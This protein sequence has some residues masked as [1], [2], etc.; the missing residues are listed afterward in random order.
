MIKSEVRAGY[1]FGNIF[2]MMFYGFT[3]YKYFPF[4]NSNFTMILGYILIAMIAVYI[5]LWRGD[6][7]IRKVAIF[8]LLPPWV[9]LMVIALPQ[10]DGFEFSLLAGCVIASLLFTRKP[11]EQ[12]IANIKT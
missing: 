3:G 5:P 8:G 1:I 10:K 2:F 7:N 9:L 6:E 11:I 12:Y 4:I